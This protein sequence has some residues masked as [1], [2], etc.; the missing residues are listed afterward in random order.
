VTPGTGSL[1]AEVAA[2]SSGDTINFAPSVTSCSPILLTSGP[3]SVTKNV[4]IAGPGASTLAVSGGGTVEV[5]T[6][7]SAA[8]A[9][10]ISGLTIEH[11]A[12][13]AGS[14]GASVTTSVPGNGQTVSIGGATSGGDGG[15]VSNGGGL[16]LTDDTVTANSTGLGGTGG[17]DTVTNAGNSD[18]ISIG[19]GGNGG[20]GGGIYNTGSLT[21]TDDTVSGNTS[22]AGGNGGSG[23]VTSTGSDEIL[24]LGAGDG[25]AGAGIYNA[26]TMTL[27]NDTVTGNTT[28]SAG[29]PGNYEVNADG[30]G[31]T[32]DLLG[33][34]GDG[35]GLF[36]DATA[37][38]T[39]ATVSSNTAYSGGDFAFGAGTLSLRS[40]IVANA[41]SGGNCASLGG[42]LSDGGH[43][44]DSATTCGLTG[45]GDKSSTNPVLGALA[46]NGGQTQTMALSSPSPAIDG[47]P[48][49]TNGCGTTVNTD[50]RGVARPQGSGC[51]MGAYEYG[52][53]AMQSLA[54][55]ANKVATGAK[56]TYTAAVVNAGAAGA[57]GVAVKDTLPAGEKF[58]S[59][60]S[61]VGSCSRSGSVVTCEIGNLSAAQDSTITIVVTVTAKKG[62]KLA[63]STTVSATTGDSIPGN[64][65][66]SKTVT[67]S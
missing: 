8:T 16:A 13:G 61:S 14:A 39:N 53:V 56:L 44:L 62:T 38:L 36:N 65:S 3:I 6:V 47:I 1:R 51:D 24:E 33:S 58:K 34:A 27:T 12:T 22:G 11:G 50:Q 20:N 25:G 17:N 35:G 55:S 66:K 5:F 57:T 21:L 30:T 60:K 45:A 52:D 29:V 18:T 54:A 31:D 2:A 10:T 49:G 19:L 43:N 9:A 42:A 67:V 23:T 32:I 59:A 26:G 28:G 37:S 7:S 63:D 41:S 46:S 64:D 40:T 48:S 4:T 15:G